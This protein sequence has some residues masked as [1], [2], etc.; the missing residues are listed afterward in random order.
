MDSLQQAEKEF[1]SKKTAPLA[2]KGASGE[3]ER[4]PLLVKK[5]L[6]KEV[7][8]MSR[9]SSTPSIVYSGFNY[10]SSGEIK[11]KQAA[12]YNIISNLA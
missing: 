10:K 4:S 8:Y 2:D 9:G 11:Q 3:K 12:G 1:L 5:E 6:S 7:S